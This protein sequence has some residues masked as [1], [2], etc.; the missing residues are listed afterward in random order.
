MYICFCFVLPRQQSVLKP[1][2]LG[3][4]EG[5]GGKYPRQLSL[6]CAHRNRSPSLPSTIHGLFFSLS[7]CRGYTRVYLLCRSRPAHGT[8]VLGAVAYLS[9]FVYLCTCT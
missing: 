6:L 7:M 9:L 5:K 4:L 1:P 8:T 3:I 2:A